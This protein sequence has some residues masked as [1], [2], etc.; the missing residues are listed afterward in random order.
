V[1]PVLEEHGGPVAT[2][3]SGFA[4]LYTESSKRA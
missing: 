2:R 3:H 1:I 4:L